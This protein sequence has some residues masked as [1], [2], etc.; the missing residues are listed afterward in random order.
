MASNK[1]KFDNNT[2]LAGAGSLIKHT[3]GNVT[4]MLLGEP[5]IGKSSLLRSLGAELNEQAVKAK[6]PP[7]EMVYVDA[8]LVDVPDIAMPMVNKDTVETHYAPN[9][10]W[11][12]RSPNRKIIMV[13]EIGKAAGPSKLVLT[14]L[15][16]ERSIG[17]IPLPAGSIVFATSNL[18]TDGV[19]DSLQAHINNRVS[20]LLVQKPDAKTWCLWGSNNNVDPMVISWVHQTPHCLASY[21]ENNQDENPYIFNPK[22]NT[23][24]FV[25][26]RSLAKAG[27]IISKRAELG[28]DLTLRGLAGCIGMRAAAD[29]EAYF[30]MADQLPTWEAIERDPEGIKLPGSATA[31]FM[32]LYGSVAQVEPKQLIAHIKFLKRFKE[33]MQA[34]WAKA[35]IQNSAKRQWVTTEK[36]FTG[37]AVDLG[38]IL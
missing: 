37:M 15:V 28:N 34:V 5:G 26:P 2:T 7:F 12:L 11:K 30:D 8:P 25:S 9:H 14:R 20:R 22:T 10:L 19:G 32:L 36:K 17:D 4:Y 29:M 31:Q 23:T 38:N 1:I 33:E 6:Q 35:M 16:L 3:G 13:D 24:A 27:F 18:S 21:L